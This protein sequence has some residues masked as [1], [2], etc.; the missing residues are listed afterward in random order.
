MF[1]ADRFSATRFSLTDSA[2]GTIPVDIS[3]STDLKAVSGASVFVLFGLSMAET[4]W[5]VGRGTISVASA[6]RA[7]VL[8]DGDCAMVANV[9]IAPS[10]AEV[11]GSNSEGCK[12]TKIVGE[13]S[14]AV[15][16][17]AWAGKNI[18]SEYQGISRAGSLSSG[19]KN[20]LSAMFTS[21]VATTVSDA[22]KLATTRAT[23]M[24]AIPP[25]GELRIDSDT[26]RVL[27]DGENILYA[28]EGDWIRVA[29]ETL[30]LD[31]ESATGG[32]MEGRMTYQ[33]RYL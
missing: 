17:N 20:V 22:G 12:D 26:F 7:E 19:S 14:S 15:H 3:F 6:F 30:Y 13:M 9:V 16:S 23:V 1:S 33:E 2:G 25:G 10:V 27:L 5:G 4:T 24:V 18:P 29:R 28:Q 32:K 31:I 21:E 8:L 11:L